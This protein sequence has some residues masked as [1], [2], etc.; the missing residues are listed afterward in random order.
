[1]ICRLCETAMQPYYN[2]GN[3]DEFRYYHC[4]VCRLVSL[5][6]T[7]RTDQVKYEL[8]P[9]N[10]EKQ[11]GKAIREKTQSY[12]F[13]RRYIPE[14]GLL[15]DIGCAGGRLLQIARDDGWD[16]TGIDISEHFAEHV[17]NSFGID[18]IAGDFVTHDFGGDGFDV[19]VLRHVLE[20]L[21]DPLVSM[22]RA[23]ELVRPGGHCFLEF[24]NIESPGLR[25]KRFIHRTGI[26][27]KRFREGFIPGHAYEFCRESFQRL[28][29]ITGFGMVRWETYSAAPLYNT[30]FNH[31][32]IGNKV[33]TIVKAV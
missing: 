1:M 20:H 5:D 11:R 8:P 18:A 31:I 28:I 14:K 17:R 22:R 16:V 2:V 10:P 24:P 27:R 12:E 32:H 7:V 19:V 29:D 25:L 6:R 4:P 23:R 3:A 21:D 33:R 26:R 13:L 9:S 30:L 15:L